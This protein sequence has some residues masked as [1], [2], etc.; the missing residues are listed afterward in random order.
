VGEAHILREVRIEKQIQKIERDKF[1]LRS[2]KLKQATMA[3]NAMGLTEWDTM[4]KDNQWLFVLDLMSSNKSMSKTLEA[5]T[6]PLI[7]KE[8]SLVAHKKVIGND[9]ESMQKRDNKMPHLEEACLAI[10]RRRAGCNACMLAVQVSQS[11]ANRAPKEKR[12]C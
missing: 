7:K 11:I 5:K 8:M 6:T 1:C 12:L 10:Q 9:V 2:L 3:M 4:T